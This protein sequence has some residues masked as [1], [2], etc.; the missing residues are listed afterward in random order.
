MK[1]DHPAV[2]LAPRWGGQPSRIQCPKRERANSALLS[3]D[4]HPDGSDPEQDTRQCLGTEQ[5]GPGGWG[6]VKRGPGVRA[7]AKQNGMST[8][9]SRPERP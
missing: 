4:Q 6:R 8:G 7:P 1:A 9:T 3:L 5:Q 2:G